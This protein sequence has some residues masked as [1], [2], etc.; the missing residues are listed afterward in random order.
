MAMINV[1][2]LACWLLYDNP[3]DNEVFREKAGGVKGNNGF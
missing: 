3:Q 1:F 2:Y